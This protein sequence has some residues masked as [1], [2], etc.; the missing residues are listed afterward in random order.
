MK[1]RRSESRSKKSRDRSTKEHSSRRNNRRSKHCSR[2]PPDHRSPSSAGSSGYGSEANYDVSQVLSSEALQVR[3]DLHDFVLV[4]AKPK[5]KLFV[6][7]G[8][9]IIAKQKESFAFGFA[10]NQDKT[11]NRAGQGESDWS[12]DNRQRLFFS[13]ESVLT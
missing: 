13:V 8:Q 10:Q 12:S 4:L 3:A 11:Q 1:E 7:T 5:A 9:N 2:S 6:L